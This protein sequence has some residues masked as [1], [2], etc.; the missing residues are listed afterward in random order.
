MHNRGGAGA[1]QAK[2]NYLGGVV[3]V[4][5]GAADGGDEGAGLGGVDG[6]GLGGEVGDDVGALVGGFD[7]AGLGGGARGA[8]RRLW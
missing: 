1:E 7:G 3:G 6:A 2:I 8:T 5:V 4:G